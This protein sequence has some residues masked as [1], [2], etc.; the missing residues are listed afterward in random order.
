MKASSGNDTGED[1]KQY[2]T[3]LMQEEGVVA[4]TLGQATKR[5]GARPAATQKV[6]SEGM[7]VAH[8]T[9]T[10]ASRRRRTAARLAYKAEHVVDLEGDLLLAA[11][12]LPATAAT[13]PKRWS[14]A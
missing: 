10:A 2:V 6:S 7:G 4:L 11:E 9:L 8:R 12:I 1:W 3:R 14:T 5:C 13:M